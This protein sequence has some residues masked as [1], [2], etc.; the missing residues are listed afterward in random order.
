MRKCFECETTEDLHEHHVVPRSRG[1][2]KTIALCYQCHM[3]AHGRDGKGIKHSRLVREGLARKKTELAKEG[4]K[5]GHENIT[6]INKLGHQANRE[7]G[8]KTVEKFYPEIKKAQRY[9]KKQAQK[10]T[11]K[12]IAELMNDREIK[13]PKGGLWFAASV[14]RIMKKV[15]KEEK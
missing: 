1:G 7:R 4:K 13:S 8:N 6:T 12:R 5:L 3:K 9:L 11:Y 2:T 14:R 10:P 15:N